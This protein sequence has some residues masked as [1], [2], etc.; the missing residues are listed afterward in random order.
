MNVVININLVL[1]K[2]QTYHLKKLL[3]VD[4]VSLADADSE[5]SD[6]YS[7]LRL[8]GLVFEERN[9]YK[10]SPVGRIVTGKIK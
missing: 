10:L 7:D 6:I 3:D 9:C 1:T 2:P 5:K 8:L 4:W